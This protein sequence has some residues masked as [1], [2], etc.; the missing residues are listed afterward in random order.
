[1]T[2]DTY[3]DTMPGYLDDHAYAAV[4]FPDLWAPLND[5]A[6]RDGTLADDLDVGEIMNTYMV[7]VR[8]GAYGKHTRFHKKNR[9]KQRKETLLS[10]LPNKET[11]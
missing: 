7:Q 5:A 1:M 4:D 11:I 9:Y 10:L 6:H 3:L 2:L 8:R